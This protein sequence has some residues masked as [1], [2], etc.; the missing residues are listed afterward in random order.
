MFKLNLTVILSRV[1]QHF[2]IL[3]KFV[4]QT[5]PGFLQNPFWHVGK[6]LFLK[7]DQNFPESEEIYIL[8][9]FC[10][11]N[12]TKIPRWKFSQKVRFPHFL[13]I[14]YHV[15]RWQCCQKIRF[16]YSFDNHLPRFTLKILK[17][18]YFHIWTIFTT[19]HV[20]N[21]PKSWIFGR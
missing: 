10:S 6:I 2:C 13:K 21:L 11:W 9:G 5:R 18:S 12:A 1:C 16:P 20:D 17:M 14:I 15:S 3:G 19:F 7:R 4:P 8:G